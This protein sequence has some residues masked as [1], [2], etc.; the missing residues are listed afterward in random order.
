MK[1]I[2]LLKVGD[3][4][5][6]GKTPYV[7][8]TYNRSTKKYSCYKW[9]DISSFREFKGDRLVDIDTIF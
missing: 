7:R 6:I 1:K 9:H 4:F 8:D 5:H 3:I 2:K